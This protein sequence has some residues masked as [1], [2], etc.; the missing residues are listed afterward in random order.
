[1]ELLKILFA[2]LASICMIM[3]IQKISLVA[4]YK[5]TEVLLYCVLYLTIKNELDKHAHKDN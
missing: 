5:P 3:L 2:L 1:M 4:G